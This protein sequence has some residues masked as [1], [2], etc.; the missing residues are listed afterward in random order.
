MDPV[1]Y[2][3]ELAD[4]EPRPLK[5]PR[6][7][8]DGDDGH[9]PYNPQSGP[10]GPQVDADDGGEGG[11]RKGRKRPLSCGECRRY[12]ST[13]SPLLGS[14]S[15]P[16]PRQA[17]AEGTLRSWWLTAAD[18]KLFI[19]RPCVPLPIVPEEGVRRNM[20]RGGPHGGQG[21]QVCSHSMHASRCIA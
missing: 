21:Q 18:T 20:S 15:P 19:V 10:S 11:T 6:Q 2:E 8:K 4:S 5:R 3:V 16:R 17:Q 12:V 9:R 7:R 14:S 1:E 13:L